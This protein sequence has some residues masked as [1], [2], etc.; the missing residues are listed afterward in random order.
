MSADGEDS[1][2]QLEAV[3]RFSATETGDRAIGL[4]FT[5]YAWYCGEGGGNIFVLLDWPP[6]GLAS[7]VVTEKLH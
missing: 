2:L 3:W 4:P 6:E 1:R 5:Q 7:I